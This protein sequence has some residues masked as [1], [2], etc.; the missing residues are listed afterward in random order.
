MAPT[1]RGR[2]RLNASR[3]GVPERRDRATN[4]PFRAT[5]ECS[6]DSLQK[7]LTLCGGGGSRL[8]PAA[9][10]SRPK[11]F[12]AMLGDRSQLRG[13]VARVVPLAAE[14]GGVKMES[15]KDFISLRLTDSG[16]FT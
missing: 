12:L 14:G 1:E 4:A 15:V 8:W 9:R 6:I 11:Q 13:A 3:P 10:P 7:G 5:V 2:A 16:A